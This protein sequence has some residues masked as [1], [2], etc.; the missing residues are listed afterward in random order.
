MTHKKE[1]LSCSFCGKNQKDVD[2]LIAGPDVNI[3]GECVSLCADIIITGNGEIKDPLEVWRGADA[4][5][6]EAVLFH[7]A[8]RAAEVVTIAKSTSGAFPAY[9][10]DAQKLERLYRSAIL[11]LQQ[12]SHDAATC[13]TCRWFDTEKSVESE[14]CGGHSEKS[15]EVDHYRVYEV[16]NGRVLPDIIGEC[17]AE[18]G[19]EPRLPPMSPVRGIAVTRQCTGEWPLPYYLREAKEGYKLWVGADRM[20]HEGKAL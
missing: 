18:R 12:A 7:L 2:K 17:W 15:T 8:R 14:S 5:S 20:I 4:G 3:C 10:R 19:R 11:I 16:V 9:V 6:R 1:G 13:G